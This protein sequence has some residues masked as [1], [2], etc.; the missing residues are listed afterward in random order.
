MSLRIMPGK[1]DQALNI[2]RNSIL[3]RIEKREGFA[4]S[5]VFSCRQ[6]NELIA[7]TLWETYESMAEVDRS[8]F[9]DQQVAKLS[10]VLAE[11][12]EGDEY[13]LEI[14]S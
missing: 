4:S 14:F 2:Y 7:C 1:M 13:E 8:G 12:A 6:K 10:G 3:P 5:L 9:L 11:S